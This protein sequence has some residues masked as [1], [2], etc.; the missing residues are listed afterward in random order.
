[1]CISKGEAEGL[2]AE[3]RH[4]GGLT[5]RTSVQKTDYQSL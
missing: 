1:M 2:K 3:L 5:L 4:A